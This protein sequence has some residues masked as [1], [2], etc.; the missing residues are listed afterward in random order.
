MSMLNLTVRFKL[1]YLFSGCFVVQRAVFFGCCFSEVTWV[2][3]GGQSVAG[4]RSSPAAPPGG[5]DGRQHGVSAGPPGGAADAALGLRTSGHLPGRFAH[6]GGLWSEAQR[7]DGARRRKPGGSKARGQGSGVI[8]LQRVLLIVVGQYIMFQ[9]IS[10]HSQYIT[11]IYLPSI[12][13][14]YTS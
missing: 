7:L 10:V 2:L 12:I 1:R 14:A 6:P 13:G 5:P 8:S 11:I 9:Y 4:A 3:T